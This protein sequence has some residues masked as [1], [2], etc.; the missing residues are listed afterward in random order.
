MRFVSTLRVKRGLPIPSMLTSSWFSASWPMPPMP[1]MAPGNMPYAIPFS[2]AISGCAPRGSGARS[3]NS[4]SRQA[5]F[6]TIRSPVGVSAPN[7]P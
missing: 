3:A 7:G 2:L 6:S 4:R 1:P 5:L